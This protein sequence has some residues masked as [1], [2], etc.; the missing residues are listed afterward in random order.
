MSKKIAQVSL[1]VNVTVLVDVEQDPADTEEQL[2]E[3][4]IEAQDDLYVTQDGER[5][6]LRIE[7]IHVDDAYV[8]EDEE[9]TG[10]YIEDLER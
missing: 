6:K 10:S 4:A 5:K 9:I 3:A 8:L 2:R 7:G 1:T